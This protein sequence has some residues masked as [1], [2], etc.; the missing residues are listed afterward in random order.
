MKYYCYLAI[1]LLFLVLY[2]FSA[3]APAF[4]LDPLH[5]NSVEDWRD[6]TEKIDTWRKLKFLCVR[7]EHQSLN[8]HCY[9]Y[10]RLNKGD[11]MSEA[12]LERWQR[13]CEQDLR[14]LSWEDF[15]R[16]PWKKLPEGCQRAWK[17]RKEEW[18]YRFSKEGAEIP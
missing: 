14:E 8:P 2:D 9:D 5:K 7:G 13:Q 17:D 12:I 1:Q 18:G 10:A 6:Q 16:V 15:L 11:V 4:F 3:A